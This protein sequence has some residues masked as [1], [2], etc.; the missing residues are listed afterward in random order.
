MLGLL[1]VLSE[2]DIL[3]SQ[4]GLNPNDPTNSDTVIYVIA[5]TTILKW[6]KLVL[7]LLLFRL[8]TELEVKVNQ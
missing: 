7:L 6:I 1:K 2:I 5:P 4:H 3:K 8:L